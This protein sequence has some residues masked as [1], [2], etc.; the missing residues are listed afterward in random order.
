MD[1]ARLDRNLSD[2]TSSLGDA[3]RRGIYVSVRESAEPVTAMEVSKRFA[4]HSNVA[5]HHLDRLAADG[6]LRVTRQRRSGRTGPGAGR[7]AKCYEATDKEIAVQFPPRRQELLADLLVQVIERVAPESAAAA[8]EEV[9]FEF[10]RQLVAEL[11]GTPGEDSGSTID[12]V[13]SIMAGVGF[14]TVPDADEPRLLTSHCP[15]GATAAKHPE[16]VCK[17]DQ[18]IVRGVLDA[19]GTSST[20]AIVTPHGATGGHCL[21]EL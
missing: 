12:A 16:V 3:T 14:E 15:F 4:I 17:I 5:R 7:P 9:G 18:G 6:Y 11:G 2:L 13:A 20:P 21:T 8:A 1:T 19:I 10:G